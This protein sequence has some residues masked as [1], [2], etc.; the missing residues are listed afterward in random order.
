M[1]MSSA[2]FFFAMLCS[3]L[4]AKS[5]DGQSSS[6]RGSNSAAASDY[7]VLNVHIAEPKDNVD[8]ELMGSRARWSREQ[9]DRLEDTIHFNTD[10][11]ANRFSMINAQTNELLHLAERKLQ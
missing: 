1:G 9:L 3:H 7:P 6:L 10:L 11:L 4:H 2:L 5:I 8:V